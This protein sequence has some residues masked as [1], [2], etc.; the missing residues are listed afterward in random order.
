MSGEDCVKKRTEA[1]LPKV[2][3]FASRLLGSLRQ[4]EVFWFDLKAAGARLWAAMAAG[5]QRAKE[6]P[7]SHKRIGA[8]IAGL[9]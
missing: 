4:K 7:I 8:I 6:R 3:F 1:R 5:Q 9:S 2:G